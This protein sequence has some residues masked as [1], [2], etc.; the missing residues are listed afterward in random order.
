MR[1]TQVNLIYIPTAITLLDTKKKTPHTI[2]TTHN[3]DRFTSPGP[4]LTLLSGIP[5]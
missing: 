4:Q 1:A 3:N 2:T 5:G